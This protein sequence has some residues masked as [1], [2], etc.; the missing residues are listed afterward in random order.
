MS[1]CGTT[2]V[3]FRLKRGTTSQWL[4]STLPLALGEPGYDTVTNDLKVGDGSSLWKDLPVVDHTLIKNVGLNAYIQSATFTGTYDASNQRVNYS[5]VLFG[6][7]ARYDIIFTYADP[8]IP[9]TLTP[10]SPSPAKIVTNSTTIYNHSNGRSESYLHTGVAPTV[11]GTYLVT[12]TV[13]TANAGGTGTGSTFS[14][15]N[16]VSISSDTMGNPTISSSSGITLNT[17]SVVRISGIDYYTSG[18][19][20]TIPSSALQLNNIYNIV[21]P[22]NFTYLSDSS[23]AISESTQFLVRAS[24]DSTY[25]GP[26][27]I[28]SAWKNNRQIAGG[29]TVSSFSSPIYSTS[30]TLPANAFTV[31]NALN[32]TNEYYYD[33]VNTNLT[34][35][36][37]S[38]NIAYVSPWNNA[39]STDYQNERLIPKNQGG[40]TNSIIGSQTRTRYA[41]TGGSLPY[42]FNI[43]EML[44]FNPSSLFGNDPLYFPFD[45]NFYSSTAPP[46]AS[47]VFPSSPSFTTGQKYL[48]IAFTNGARL[49]NFTLDLVGTTGISNIYVA[50]YLTNGTYYG[51]YDGRILYNDGS[52]GCAARGPSAGETS[53]QFNVN[54]IRDAEYVAANLGGTIYVMIKFTGLV[55]L[56]GLLLT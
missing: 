13:S 2:N 43:N 37:P 48:C 54:Q 12:M 34:T 41:G 25:P 42:S 7:S 15:T 18:T 31:T 49:R 8:N 9:P 53:W 47:Y 3:K 17:A 39:G 36:T 51:W 20:L 46:F 23:P 5:I 10:I 40:T 28:N 16:S 50:W 6:N 56:S 14:V 35:G 32:K 27:G 29:M 52:T 21:N 19:T 33:A 22:S 1:S 11:G 24:D 45:G 55:K 44:T 38:R 30:R 4:A 26:S